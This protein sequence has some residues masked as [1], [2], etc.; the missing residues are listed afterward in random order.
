[1]LKASR[2]EEDRRDMEVP[3]SLFALLWGQVAG[4][5]ESRYKKSRAAG[6]EEGGADVRVMPGVT[7]R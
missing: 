1:M 2:Y 3:K 4:R 7:L 5:G 6:G